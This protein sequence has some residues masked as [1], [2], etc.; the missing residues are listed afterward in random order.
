MPIQRER[1]GWL[2][3]WWVEMNVSIF[4][5]VKLKVLKVRDLQLCEYTKNHSNNETMN[6]WIV[7]YIVYVSMTLL[8]S[9]VKA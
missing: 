1:N 8:K 6:S 2:G 3:K 7:L 9:D 4:L 5:K